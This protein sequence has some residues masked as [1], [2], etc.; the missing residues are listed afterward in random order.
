MQRHFL[1]TT[2]ARAATMN[3]RLEMAQVLWDS[4]SISEQLSEAVRPNKKVC[5]RMISNKSATFSGGSGETLEDLTK[6]LTRHIEEVET[7]DSW[8]MGKRRSASDA[9]A[10]GGDT[11]P[12][13][14][15]RERSGLRWNDSE[16]GPQDADFWPSPVAEPS[17][18]RLPGCGDVVLCARLPGLPRGSRARQTAVASDFPEHGII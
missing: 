5:I 2:D 15:R 17:A 9:P 11:Q 8:V 14:R 3:K 10:A 12:D 16:R 13:P 1:L 4:A 18:L 6:K 7:E